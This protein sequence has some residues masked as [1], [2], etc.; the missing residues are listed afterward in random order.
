MSA[1][2]PQVLS[3]ILFLLHKS[4]FEFYSD[5]IF[6][7]QNQFEFIPLCPAWKFPILNIKA[8]IVSIFDIHKDTSLLL[9]KLSILINNGIMIKV[10]PCLIRLNLI[11]SQYLLATVLQNF[12]KLDGQNTLHY[13]NHFF[14]PFEYW[15]CIFYIFQPR[16]NATPGREQ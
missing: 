8:I 5:M 10:F 13:T 15:L 12:V 16:Y 11:E 9:K 2:Y 4:L 3:E 14:K 1:E 6:E 7:W